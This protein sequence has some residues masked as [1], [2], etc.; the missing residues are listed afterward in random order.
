[1]NNKGIKVEDMRMREEV[2]YVSDRESESPFYVVIAGVSYCDGSYHIKRRESDVLCMEYIMEG[3]GTVI[4]DGKRFYA[5]KG[6]VY[7]LRIGHNHEYYSDEDNPWIKIWLNVSGTLCEAMTEA[8]GLS[9]AVIVERA[10]VKEYFERAVQLCKKGGDVEK[11]NEEIAIIFHEIIQRLSQSYR[12][13]KRIKRSEA[14]R[15]KSYIDSNF[16]QEFDIEQLAKNIYKSKSQ[17]IRIF[18]KEYGKTPYD[19]FLGQ[20]FK[21]AG[22]LLRNTN[23]LIKEIA[24]Q[25]GFQD[26]HYFSSLFKKRFGMSPREYRRKQ[27]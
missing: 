7:L 17:A 26:E 20:R 13:K 25:S 19:Y 5:N 4:Q 14:A 11:I 23:M 8:Y 2:Y 16:P 18:K 22:E 6:D 24:Y 1:M 3:S 27:E 21:L 9:S 15:M 10:E 12:E